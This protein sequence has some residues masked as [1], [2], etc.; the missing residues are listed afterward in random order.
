M[1]TYVQ[2]HYIC[3]PYFKGEK[4]GA[5]GGQVT[6]P[7]H[8]IRHKNGVE[9]EAQAMWLLGHCSSLST[10]YKISQVPFC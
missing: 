3:L 2:L 4:S 1:I 10:T 8:L 7:G 9:N 6:C 5:K